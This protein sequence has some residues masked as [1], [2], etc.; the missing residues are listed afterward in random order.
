MENIAHACFRLERER[1]R[2]REGERERGD[3]LGVIFKGSHSRENQNLL[4]TY[5]SPVSPVFHIEVTV[6]I[7]LKNILR[8]GTSVL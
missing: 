4:I 5:K 2:E 1:E 7:G 3:K 8:V 6:R